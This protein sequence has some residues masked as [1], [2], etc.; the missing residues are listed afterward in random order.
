MKGLKVVLGALGMGGVIVAT[1]IP[2][3]VVGSA[4]LAFHIDHI[5]GK[6]SNSQLPPFVIGSKGHPGA[7][8]RQRAEVAPSLGGPPFQN[9]SHRLPQRAQRRRSIGRAHISSVRSAHRT[10]RALAASNSGPGTSARPTAAL[11]RRTVG[12]PTRR[13]RTSAKR[14]AHRTV[15]AVI[16]AA[17]HLRSHQT[18]RRRVT[19]HRRRHAHKRHARHRR[20]AKLRH[21][22][23][24]RR[25]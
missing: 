16:S 17:T 10:P 1:L 19:S 24:K 15:R 13:V 5:G 18:Q 8:G 22:A 2:L 20:H 6:S 12:S 11:A 9:V 14:S 3:L 21:S 25:H 4:L 23:S 7:K